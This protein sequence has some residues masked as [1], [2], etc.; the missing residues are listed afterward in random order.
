MVC[1]AT[2]L[3]G[4]QHDQGTR[5]WLVLSMVGPGRAIALPVTS[6]PPE[7]GYPLSWPVPARWGLEQASW[8]R[9]DHARSL[10]A[11]RLRDPFAEA[12]RDELLE[13]LDALGELLGCAI[14][15]H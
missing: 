14:N 5:P 10:P 15:P 2:V 8:L 1:W 9:V 13:V 11:D 12:S 4:L 6:V 7:Y 3:A